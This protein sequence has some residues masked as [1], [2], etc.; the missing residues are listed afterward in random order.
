MDPVNSVRNDAAFTADNEQQ[1]GKLQCWMVRCEAVT[2]T[3]QALNS[4]AA[5]TNVF[6]TTKVARSCKYRIVKVETVIRVKHAGASADNKCVV[7]TGNGAASETFAD[8]VASVDMDSD[9]VDLPTNRAI[10]AAECILLTGETLRVQY[11]TVGNSTAG[12][13]EVYIWAIPVRA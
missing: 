9:T 12:E 7:E 1:F 5:I 11:I 8:L 4:A 13:L 10:V 6:G 2:A 3:A